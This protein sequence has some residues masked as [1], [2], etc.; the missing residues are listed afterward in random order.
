MSTPYIGSQQYAINYDCFVHPA[1]QGQSTDIRKFEAEL[2]Q[3]LATLLLA[4]YLRTK[5]EEESSAPKK[6][7]K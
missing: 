6:E 4:D 1:I 2:D 5:A 3:R 7:K